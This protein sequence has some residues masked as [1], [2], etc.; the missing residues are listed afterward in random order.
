MIRKVKGG[1]KVFS[2]TKGALSKKPMSKAK[3]KAQHRAVMA[4]KARRKKK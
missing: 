2:S 1:F 4:S 3:A